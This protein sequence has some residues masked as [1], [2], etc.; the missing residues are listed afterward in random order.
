MLLPYPD[1][2][3]LEADTSTIL[4]Y[5]QAKNFEE[6]M[7]K[8]KLMDTLSTINL[9][10]NISKKRIRMI[11][12]QIKVEQY[13][14]NQVIFKEGDFGDKFF[15][16]KSGSVSI[17]INGKY[18]RTMNP[19]EYFGEKALLVHNTRTAT[20]IANGITEVYTLS[21]TDFLKDI[22]TNMKNFLMDRQFLQDD[23]IEL[24]DLVFIKELGKGNYGSV[25]LVSSKKNNYLYAIKAINIKQ[26]IFEKMQKNLKLEKNILLQIDH[27]FIVKLVKCMKDSYNIYFLMEY[28]KGADLFDV[29]R[30]IG[31]LSKPQTQFY[32][33]S[34]MLAINYLHERKFIYRD[35]KPENIIIIKNGYLKLVDFGTAKAIED[36]T[37]TIIGT[38]HYMAP[39]VILGEGYSFQVDYWSIGICTYEFCCGGVPFGETNEDPMDIYISIIKDKLNFP[40]F[41]KD[42]E[43]K[44][45]MKSMLAKN[46][47]KR[48]T[49]FEDIKNHSWFQDFGWDDILE[50]SI[51]PPYKPILIN[52]KLS[53]GINYTQ[54]INQ[55]IQKI[56][57]A[58]DIQLSENE[59]A[60]FE[61]WYKTF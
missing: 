33:A 1:V 20:A 34:M 59:A 6:I 28:L 15:I 9:F 13:E 12:S 49:K 27:P 37:S 47:I 21:K 38:P 17:T 52:D 60:Q 32:T 18:I 35:I 16:V 30:E 41:C 44:L 58:V 7:S 53:K 40:V 61:E 54:Y 48:M 24:D 45:L 10:K 39:E 23:T 3:F 14:D 42:K 8:N 36:R 22:E 50:F 55:C 56:D 25:S 43:F 46:P 26:I 4:T 19:K 57:D 29:I 2:L 31:L 5:S 51:N 11:C